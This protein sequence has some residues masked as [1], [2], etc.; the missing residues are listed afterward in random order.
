MNLSMLRRYYNQFCPLIVI[1]I[2]IKLANEKDDDEKKKAPLRGALVLFSAAY[3]S[4]VW[5]M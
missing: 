3:A 2:F 1:V 4:I 5:I